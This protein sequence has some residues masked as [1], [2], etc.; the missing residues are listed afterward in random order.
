LLFGTTLNL[1]NQGDAF[2]SGAMLNITKCL[3]TWIMPYN[4]KHLRRHFVLPACRTGGGEH[5]SS[6]SR[7]AIG[8]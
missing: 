8:N 2:V 4:V 6:T 3:L 5:A 7:P 1:F